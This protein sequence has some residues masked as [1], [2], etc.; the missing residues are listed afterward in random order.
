MLSYDSYM[1][2]TAS[3]V[4]SGGCRISERGGRGKVAS[5]KREPKF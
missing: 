4:Y 5:A 3:I 1:S 2:Y